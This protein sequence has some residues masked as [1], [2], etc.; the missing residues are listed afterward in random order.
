MVDMPVIVRHQDRGALRLDHRHDQ[1]LCR[2]RAVIWSLITGIMPNSG[3]CTLVYLC[4]ARMAP[5]IPPSLIHPRRQCRIAPADSARQAIALYET[6]L[7]AQ[8]SRLWP[9][10]SAGQRSGCGRSQLQDRRHGSP[11]ICNPGPATAGD[12]E[13]GFSAFAAA[14][15]VVARETGAELAVVHM[16]FEGWLPARRACPAQASGDR[17]PE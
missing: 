14:G 12:N 3:R 15:S 5:T 10:P 8:N 6:M 16:V 11:R 17:C 7:G 1:A 2:R 9:G 13:E 4:A